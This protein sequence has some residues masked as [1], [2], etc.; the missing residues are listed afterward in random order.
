MGVMGRWDWLVGAGRS[1]ATMVNFIPDIN[2]TTDINDGHSETHSVVAFHSP[3]PPFT[4]SRTLLSHKY[5]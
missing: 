1:D 4:R 5:Q 3:T 2:F